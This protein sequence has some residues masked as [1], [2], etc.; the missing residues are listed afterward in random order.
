[1]ENEIKFPP[2]LTAL[3]VWLEQ[4]QKEM[5]NIILAG[6]LRNLQSINSCQSESEELHF[7]A[8]IVFQI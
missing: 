4:F 1:M 7:T 6:R 8:Y 3:L 5:L 2:D